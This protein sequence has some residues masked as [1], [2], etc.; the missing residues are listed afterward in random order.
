MSLADIQRQQE[1]Q[2]RDVLACHW[3]WLNMEWQDQEEQRR[4]RVQ[5]EA[6]QREAKQVGAA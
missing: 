4:R 6:I 5:E 2:V 1:Q 3:L